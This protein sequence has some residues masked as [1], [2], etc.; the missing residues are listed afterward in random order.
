MRNYREIFFAYN[1]PGP[2]PCDFCKKEVLAV[3]LDIHHRDGDHSNDNPENLVAAHRSCHASHHSSGR[4][5][6]EHSQRMKD[7]W[8]SGKYDNKKKSRMTTSKGEDR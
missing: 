2:W 6:P 7:R 3:D 4:K 1:G 8:A 5:S